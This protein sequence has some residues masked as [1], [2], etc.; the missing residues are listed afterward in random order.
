MT[1]LFQY[2]FIKKLLQLF[3]TIVD[4]ELLKAVVLEILWT[5]YKKKHFMIHEVGMCLKAFN[6]YTITD[7]LL[8]RTNYH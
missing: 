5:E 3:I 8:V 2:A 4:A 6:S 7:T 1:H